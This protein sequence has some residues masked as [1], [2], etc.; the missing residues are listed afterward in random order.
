[1]FQYPSHQD[2]PQYSGRSLP[3]C[4]DIHELSDQFENWNPILQ[5]QILAA[6]L[7]LLRPTYEISLEISK[8]CRETI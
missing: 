5:A 7:S 2:C 6:V 3:E 1:M 4:L 8:K